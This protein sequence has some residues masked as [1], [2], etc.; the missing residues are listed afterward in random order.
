MARMSLS[1]IESFLAVAEEGHMGRAARR[2]HISQ[3]PLSRRIQQLEDELCVQLFERS[4]RGMR[5]SPAGERLLAHA[6]GILAAV[7]EARSAVRA[8]GVCASPPRPRKPPSTQ[9]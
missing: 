9:A 8:E 6:R 5:L 4:A 1:Q 2:L 3:P 7:A